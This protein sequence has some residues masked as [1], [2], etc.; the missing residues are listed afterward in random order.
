[1]DVAG[2]VENGQPGRKARSDVAHIELPV[3]IYHANRKA[4]INVFKLRKRR[5]EEEMSTERKS[6]YDFLIYK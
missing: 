3:M 1:M 2:R 6:K 5:K 4:K